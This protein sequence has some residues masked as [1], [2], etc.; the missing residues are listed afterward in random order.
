MDG[1]VSIEPHPRHARSTSFCSSLWHAQE[2]EMHPRGMVDASI[3][4]DAIHPSSN[5]FAFLFGLILIGF[6]LFFCIMRNSKVGRRSRVLAS[7]KR[8]RR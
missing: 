2:D 8:R 7:E 3:F 4:A 6:L 5:E 1:S